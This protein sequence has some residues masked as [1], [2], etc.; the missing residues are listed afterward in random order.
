VLPY[1][2]AEARAQVQTL[3]ENC[4]RFGVE[5]FDFDSAHRGIVHVIGPELGLTQPGMTIVCGDS[6]HRHPRRVRRTGLRHRHQRGRPRHGY[7]VPA[8]AQART[9]A[10]TVDGELGAGVTAKD[11]ILHVIG[12]IGVNGGTGHV[13]EYRGTAI[14]ALSM[15]ERMTV[16]NMSIEAG[17]RAGLIA[18]DEITF[19]YLRGR[20]R[21]PQGAGF[22]AAVAKW[23]E[24][25]SDDGACFDREVRIDAGDIRPTVTWGTHP[26]Q[27]VALD[28]R[29]RPN[30]DSDEAKARQYM[31]W[32]PARPWP[33]ARGRGL[34]R[35]LHQ[36]T[37]GRPARRCG[38]VARP[39]GASARTHAG[40]ARFRTG[41]ARSRSR[42][43]RPDRAGGRCRVA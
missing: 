39:S 34:R 5:L 28:G 4:A 6:P 18:P 11:L 9:I 42:G 3:R 23:R 35:Q 25:R 41:Q 30:A 2:S 27:V 14:R 22:D 20:P 7:A 26:G 15:D 43:H 32:R 1:T 16:C 8:A 13:I 21:V 38:G 24:L 36:L 10:I 17:A 19:D 40:R 37:P 33:G 12:V 29:V 31:G